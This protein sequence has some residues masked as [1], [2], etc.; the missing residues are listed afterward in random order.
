M[1]NLK[2]K[3]ETILFTRWFLKY[4]QQKCYELM[5]MTK[6]MNAEEEDNFIGE[7]MKKYEG[8]RSMDKKYPGIKIL[9]DSDISQYAE[10][11]ENWVISDFIK[12]GG[13]VVLGGKRSTLKSWT[14][15]IA[16]YCVANGLDFLGRF[17]CTQRNVL[18]LDRE[19]GFSGLKLRA[20]LVRNGLNLEKESNVIF[21]SESYVKIDNLE[22]VKKLEK[23]I[24]DNSIGLIVCDVYRR[25]VS[26]DEN[27]AKEVSKL[28]VDYLKPLCERTGVAFLLIHHERKGK[29][30][31]DDMDML[32]GSSDLANYVDSIIQVDRKFDFLTIKQ[33]K[34][35]AG[36]EVEPFQVKSETDEL[37]YFKLTYA[38]TIGTK[39]NK[40]ARALVDWVMQMK[41]REFT[42]TQALDH[43]RDLGGNK[44]NISS[45]LA[46]LTN[47][48]IITKGGS[49]RDPYVVS[50]DLFG[51]GISN[52][53]GG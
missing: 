16:S 36:K 38:G 9:W 53:K 12:V 18:Y 41:L 30:S 7:F 32:R 47:K 52:D 15:L 50:E 19:N 51:K 31:G 23:V 13:I 42:F 40:M 1:Y 33:T 45:A 35:R 44:N 28:F 4:D 29:S 5:K 26:F 48:G 21:L 11:T 14:A 49:T 22:D 24:V 39:S 17:K 8:I 43:C 10:Q 46:E 20:K 6:N 3:D 37:S 25:L 34:N 27:D 2:N